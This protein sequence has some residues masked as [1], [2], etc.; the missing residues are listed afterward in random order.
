MKLFLRDRN[1]AM[2]DAWS[3]AFAGVDDVEVSCGPIFD[4]PIVDSLVS[5]AN[6]FGFMDGGIDQVYTDY[7]G[8]QLQGRLQQFIRTQLDGEL[9][10]GDAVVLATGDQGATRPAIKWLVSAPTMRVP[11][12]VSNSVNAYLALRA[13]LLAVRSHN[14]RYTDLP[15]NQI[16]SIMCPGLGTAIGQMPP[17]RCALQMREAWD[18][19]HLGVHHYFPSIRAAQ[20]FHHAMNGYSVKG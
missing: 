6:S 13:T 20:D 7:F 5:P 17:E 8:Q 15:E 1:Q 9:I 14:K 12:D 3:S 19:I 16:S 4:G 18:Q 11:L 2:A 10:V